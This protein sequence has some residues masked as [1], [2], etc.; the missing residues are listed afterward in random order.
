MTIVQAVRFGAKILQEHQIENAQNDSFALLA[1]VNGMN[2]TYYFMHGEDI[3]T[4][5]QEQCFRENINK[6]AKHI[7]LQHI[8][9]EAYFFGYAFEVNESVLVPRPDTEVLVE[10]VLALTDEH[11]DVIDMCTGSGCIILSLALQGHVHQGY[12][13]D[14]SKDALAV[15]ERN[16]RKHGIDCVSFI[17]SDVFTKV[18]AQ[19]AFP[20]K[21]ADVIVSNPPYIRTDVIQ[22]LSEE[23]RLH[24]PMMALDG[25]ADGLFF[26]KKITKEAVQ[27]LRRGGFLCYEIGH[28]QAEDVVRIMKE[29]G[30]TDIRVIQDYAGLDRVV[31]G[32]LL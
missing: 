9:G 10:Q 28:D 20:E 15:A 18:A 32:R 12:G 7:P 4:E 3:L 6:R 21:K 8:L 23:V 26:Y 2:R 17:E 19:I 24:D 27:Y 13:V 16:K 30:Y 14:Y 11:S 25:H 31:L 5:K 1:A 29:N 22:T